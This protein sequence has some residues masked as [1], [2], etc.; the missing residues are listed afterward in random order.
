MTPAEKIIADNNVTAR[1]A[2]WTRICRDAN[3]VPAV[4]IT[5]DSHANPEALGVVA[6]SEYPLAFVRMLLQ[7]AL[8]K[9]EDGLYT[10][11]TQNGQT[12][13]N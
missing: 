10:A 4:L 3:S 1:L 8:E 2:D 11:A 13:V 6:P 9:V 7:A 5:F 12:I